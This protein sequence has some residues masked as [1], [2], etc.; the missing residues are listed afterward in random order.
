[1]VQKN[2]KRI[3]YLDVA[4]GIGIMTVVWAHASGPFSNYIYQF[5]MPFFFLISGYLFNSKSSLQKFVYGKVKSLYIPFAVWNLLI[6]FIKII[7]RPQTLKYNL[8][9]MLKIML[10]L[11]K[12]G[13]FFGATWFLGALFVVS[14]LY[15]VFD[16]CIDEK[17][18]K[19]W[20]MAAIFSLIGIAGFLIDFE[21]MLS[22]TMVLSMFYAIGYLI[23]QEKE[24]LKKIDNIVTCIICLLVFIVIGRNNFAN[25]GANEYGNRILFVIGALAASYVLICVSR[26]IAKIKFSPV[27]LIKKICCFFG[28]KSID[29]VIWQFVTFRIVIAASLLVSN[30]SLKY[31]LDY[32]P[33]HTKEHGWWI[34]YFVVGMLVSV[35][36]GS[37]IDF[38]KKNV[39]ALFR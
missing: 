1:M 35:L 14:V 32:Y 21:Y 10:T 12:D 4:K 13:Q 18:S 31:I 36:I 27:A 11:E 26:F 33:V 34:A 30:I 22:R 3:E 25:M 19:K 37:V 17:A 8:I 5:H 24:K 9:R 7:L 15:K 39:Y 23:K 6:T 20:I 16:L 29:I 2:S 28:E 38:V